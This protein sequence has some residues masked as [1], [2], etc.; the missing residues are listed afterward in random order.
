MNK[1]KTCADVKILVDKTIAN[2][3]STGNTC[4]NT[5]QMY[6]GNV[7]RKKQK[8]IIF[9]WCII[10]LPWWLDRES[11]IGS[12]I[13][14]IDC[15]SDESTANRIIVRTAIR[16]VCFNSVRPVNNDSKRV[17]NPSSQPVCDWL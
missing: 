4:A 17:V 7:N 14:S 11:T 13:S 10:D 15:K 1:S 2:Q 8:N 3:K 12:A 5:M 6:N 16:A 9:I